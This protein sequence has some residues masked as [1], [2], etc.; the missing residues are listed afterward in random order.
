MRPEASEEP[1]EQVMEHGIVFE[2]VP[3]MGARGR[4]GESE[5][6]VYYCFHLMTKDLSVSC[7]T[8]LRELGVECL[9]D[10]ASY[11]AFGIAPDSDELLAELEEIEEIRAVEKREPESTK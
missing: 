10:G 4:A 9:S 5:P 7:E 8:K 3:S 11:E 6:M 2:E 1:E